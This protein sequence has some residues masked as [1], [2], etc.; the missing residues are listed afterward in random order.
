MTGFTWF[1][2]VT[3]AD[4]T[5]ARRSR[6]VR[7]LVRELPVRS[8][9]RR[10]R[11]RLW[12][13]DAQHLASGH[14]YSVQFWVNDSRWDGFGRSETITSGTSTQTPCYNSGSLGQL[15]QYTLGYFSADGTTQFFNLQPGAGGI[16]MNALQVRDLTGTWSGAT[17]GT[18]SS[19]D[20][21]SQNFSGLSFA[22]AGTGVT[23]LVSNVFFADTSATGSAVAASA[24]TVAAGGVSIGNVYFQNKAVA[25][26]LGSADAVGITGTTAVT[27][28]GGG[29]V[30][31]TGTNTYTGGT[32]V[33][34]GILTVSSTA[35]LPGYASAGSVSTA[36]AA[37]I[38]VRVSGAGE[39]QA[40]DI[41]AILAHAS[42]PSGA[43]LGI[44]TTDG[45]FTYGSN[46]A[47]IGASGAGGLSKLGA[48]T[49]LLTGTNTY[50]GGT[51]VNAGILTASSTAALP[52]YA[53]AGSV[54]AAAGATIAVRVSGA[55]EWQAGDIDSLRADASIPSGA[56]LGIDT[57][58]GNFTYGSNIAGIGSGG[59]GG[60]NKLGAGAAC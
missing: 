20:S 5:A 13:G 60:L 4:S 49:L 52:G 19:T 27:V 39:W 50:T 31:F 58:D 53:S 25:Y 37:T 55:G 6:T 2:P 29:L 3:S 38:A 36:A 24:V 57:T 10:L 40:G 9:R 17:N 51:T 8:R 30:T 28:E 12:N 22:G 16:Q 32:T 23:S 59:A 48:G 1:V 34:A 26:T 7:Q 56:M 54:S 18:W 43:M 44:D 35:A 47:G 14:Q 42:I 46:I 15:G 11:Q 21:T 41:D 33:S 45:N